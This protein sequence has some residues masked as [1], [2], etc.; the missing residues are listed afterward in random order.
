MNNTLWKLPTKQKFVSA[1]NKLLSLVTVNEEASPHITENQYPSAEPIQ[2]RRHLRFF[3]KQSYEFKGEVELHEVG[4]KYLR[5]LFNLTYKDKLLLSYPV[6]QR[7]KKFMER[8][9]GISIDL[10]KNDYFLES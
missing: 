4:E 9:S 7:Q 5:K 3:D 10:S 6:S 8:L 2:A 1:D